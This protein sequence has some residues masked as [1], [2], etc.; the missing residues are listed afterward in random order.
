MPPGRDPEA[1]VE[2]L[3]QRFPDAGFNFRTRDKA[4]PGAER[5]VSRMG[6]F[7][8]LVGLAALAIAGI[9]IGGGVSSYL[10]ARRT[11]IATLKVLGAASG[12]IARIY[13]LQ[14]GAAALAGSLAGLVAGVLV[15]PLLAQA[16]GTLLPVTTGFVFA[17][18]ALADRGRLWPAGRA[19]LRRAAAR[20]RAR[21]PGHGADARARLAARAAAPRA[22]AA[23][24]P[25]PGRH[26]RAGP[27]Q[28][29]ADRRDRAV[30]GRSGRRSSRCSARWAGRSAM[31][32]PACRAR[33]SRCCA[34]ALPTCTAPARRP[35]RWSPRWASASRPSCCSRRSRPVS[36]P[37]SARAFRQRAPDY[38][39]LDVPRERVA[40]FEHGRARGD[41]ARDDPQGSGAARRD[42]R[43]WP[44]RADDARCR[45][46]G[47]SRQRLGAARRAR[48]DLCRHGARGQFAGRRHMVAQGLFRP[49]AGLGRRGIGQC[50]SA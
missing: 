44:R 23:G 25:R 37:I 45:S 31:S 40:A 42:H 29:R 33:A 2:M 7:L 21:L 15:T 13:L 10:E 47:H 46:Q 22:A 26:R 27:G 20:P 36:T 17:P 16:L 3:K 43:L 11:S 1:T 48:A 14:I 50:A 5:F 9:G 39:V 4:A 35:A 8:V 32:P 38:F 6:E 41:P 24:R 28:C 49:A 12:D 18:A 19:G 30:P 34:P